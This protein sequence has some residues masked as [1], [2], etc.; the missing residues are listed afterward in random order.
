MKGNI[1]YRLD[2][3]V[4]FDKPDELMFRSQIDDR[5]LQI[6]RWGEADIA[7]LNNPFVHQ[8]YE[9]TTKLRDIVVGPSNQEFRRLSEIAPILQRTVLNTED[10]FFY[11]HQG[12]EEEAFKLSIVTNI[13]ERA[14]KRGASTISML[15]VKHL[16]LH[17][18]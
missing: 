14:F 5:N 8:V 4:D 11:E 3:K 2:F 10:P 7:A 1:A 15:L 16:Y 13:K 6:V 12:F 17:R 18:N 9:D